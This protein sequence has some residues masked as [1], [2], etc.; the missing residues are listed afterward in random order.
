MILFA[1]HEN[2]R[3]ICC[4]F[5][6]VFFFSSEKYIDDSAK[7]V[8]NQNASNLRQHVRYFVQIPGSDHLNI[9]ITLNISLC[10]IS[11][12]ASSFIHSTNAF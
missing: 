1:N 3:L 6:L 12:S 8:C 9:I 7:A 10:L 11:C 5:S 4:G 2:S